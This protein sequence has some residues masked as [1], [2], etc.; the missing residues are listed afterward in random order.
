MPGSSGNPPV[1]FNEN[2]EFWAEHMELVYNSI[3]TANVIEDSWKGSII[4]PI[5]KGGNSLDPANF[6]PVPLFEVEL[7]YFAGCLLEELTSWAEEQ[8]IIPLN[9]TGFSKGIGITINI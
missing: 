7:K 1:I 4:S 9:Q 5:Y 3:T 2:K 6:W 8:H